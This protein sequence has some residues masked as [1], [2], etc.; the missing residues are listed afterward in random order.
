MRWVSEMEL[1]A[2]NCFCHL[3]VGVGWRVGGG[4]KNSSPQCYTVV[5][6][7]STILRKSKLKIRQVSFSTQ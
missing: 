2:V 1:G 3:P 4:G 6:T 7:I 5:S